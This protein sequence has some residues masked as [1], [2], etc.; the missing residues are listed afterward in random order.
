MQM[1]DVLKRLA[2]LDSTNPSIV[3]ENASIEEC[4]PMGM[5]GGMGQSHTPA[6]ISMSA[7]SGEELSGM[8]G[9]IMKLAGIEKVEPHHM[10]MEPEPMNLT[11]EPIAAVGPAPSAGDE[12]RSVLDKMNGAGG[13]EEFGDE[14]GEEE[15]DEGQY[16]NSPADPNGANPFDAEEFANHPNKGSTHGRATKNNPHGNPANHEQEKKNDMTME[17]RLMAEYKQY[18]AEGAEFGAYYNEQ[19]AQQVFD[20]NPNLPV[21]GKCEE[22]LDAGYKIAVQDLGKK[23]ARYK[24]G[25]DEDF[26]SDF[27]SSYHYLQKQHSQQSEPSHDMMEG[28]ECPSCHKPIKKCKCD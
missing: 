19:L 2:E 25:Y 5:M 8:L 1:I 20:E 6:S 16:D 3:K 22:L 21:E 27:V 11:A 17:Q 26:P 12:M 28:K 18:V 4:G 14:D 7:D 15:T 13:E 9:A 10:G 23:T 24:F